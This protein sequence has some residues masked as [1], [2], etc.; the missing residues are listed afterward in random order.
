M[1]GAAVLT[2]LISVGKA[3]ARFFSTSYKQ[4]QQRKAT[5]ENLAVI[6]SLL[7]TDIDSALEGITPQMQKTIDQLE[8]AL[9]TPGQ[10]VASK[11]KILKRSTQ[12]L[13]LLSRQI[14]NVGNL[15]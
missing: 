10:Q 14:S 1:G 15:P 2:S 13:D 5:N 3:L 12:K 4:S 6:R 9:K 11:A 8:Q 7:Q